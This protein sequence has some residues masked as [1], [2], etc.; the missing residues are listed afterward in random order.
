MFAQVYAAHLRI[1]ARFDGLRYY[2]YN[3]SL[4]A[5]VIFVMLFSFS[6]MIFNALLYLYFWRD[7]SVPNGDVT[8]ADGQ[9]QLV[10]AP[11]LKVSDRK[12]FSSNEDRTLSKH[13]LIDAPALSSLPSPPSER[14]PPSERQIHSQ[15]ETGPESAFNAAHDL[16]EDSQ[17]SPPSVTSEELIV[18]SSDMDMFWCDQVE[19]S[20]SDDEISSL[21][22]HDQDGQATMESP[23]SSCSLDSGCPPTQHPS[24]ETLE[25]QVKAPELPTSPTL[26]AVSLS[27]ASTDLSTA[28]D[29]PSSP[30]DSDSAAPSDD[31]CVPDNGSSKNQ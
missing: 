26:S 29:T 28:G 15:P 3:F 10:K 31:S 14:E 17:S 30:P 9:L 6:F 24:I 1:D 2:M 11:L 27:K 8:V 4:P 7:E 16:G 20:S 23:A 19:H 21:L 5:G 22:N 18:S 13:R 12:K 25:A